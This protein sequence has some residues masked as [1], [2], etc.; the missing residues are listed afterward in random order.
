MMQKTYIGDLISESL[1]LFLMPKK[2]LS[3]PFQIV[4]VTIP[5]LTSSLNEPDYQAV[6]TTEIFYE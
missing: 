6:E 5:F 2:E 1:K 4:V 3:D